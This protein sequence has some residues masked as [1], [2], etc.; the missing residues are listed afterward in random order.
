MTVPR[1][2]VI[3]PTFNY[4][5]YVGTAVESVLAQTHPDVEVVVVDDGST[6]ST[7]SV[8]V[9]F[10]PRIRLIR[11]SQMGVA[12]ARNRGVRESTG[13]LLAFLDADDYWHVRKLERQVAAHGSSPNAG[14]VHCG[15]QL[16]DEHG[17]DSGV[18]QEGIS[19]LDATSLL[20][21]ESSVLGGGSGALIPR[22]VFEEAG[23]FDERMSTSADYDL[24]VRIASRWPVVLIPDLLVYY[25]LHGQNMHR[26][27]PAMEHDVMLVLEKAFADGGRPQLRRTAYSKLH[28]VL[29]GSY[30]RSGKIGKAAAHAARSC[31]IDPRRVAYLVSF[32]RR[33]VRA[34]R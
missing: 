14:L 30:F 13:D 29:A 33:R 28:M 15:I 27:V 32:P 7:A 21:M 2:S 31:F 26:N 5:R 11:Q 22:P 18:R 24:Y 19:G 25:R 10:G 1:V 3:I 20:L 16:V 8:L 34:W 4:G 12:A 9:P 23:G 17:R 6:D